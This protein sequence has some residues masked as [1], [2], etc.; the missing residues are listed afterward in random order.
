MNWQ[1]PDDFE[2]PDAWT[3]EDCDLSELSPEDY[4][5]WALDQLPEGEVQ[6]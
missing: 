4:P 6:W 3:D 1:D 2:N 5:A